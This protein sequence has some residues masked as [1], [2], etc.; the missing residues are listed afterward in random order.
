MIDI[1]QLRR[2]AQ[3]ATPGPWTAKNVSGAG[4]E[5]HM[6]HPL[7]PDKEWPAFG[8]DSAFC[9]KGLVAYETWTQFPHE[10]RDVQ[11]AKNASFI[12]AA[13]PAAVSE[14]LDRLEA[15]EKGSDNA[16]AAAAGIALQT[17]ELQAKLEAAEKE[18]DHLRAELLGAK[19]T[20]RELL[21]GAGVAN[22]TIA[23]LRAKIEAMEKQEPV[24]KV[25]VHQTGG[26][27]GIA[28]SVAP[29]NDFDALPLMRD[30][31][32]LYALP[33]AQPAPSTPEGW[34]LVPIEPTHEMLD[35]GEDTYIPTYTGTSV[36]EPIDVYRAMLAAAP[37]AKP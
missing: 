18:R 16:N 35:A 36:S 19:E 20:V 13:N 33:G 11:Q 32:K 17:A 34:K 12:A 9:K 6:H 24:A 31:S 2:L 25:R 8:T 3:E 15:A 14:L 5:I 21:H 28:W 27:A 1:D 10:V 4:L 26:N 7:Y 23:T 22:M 37:E 30:G 29:L